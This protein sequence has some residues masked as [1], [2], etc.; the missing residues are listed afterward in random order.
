[1][2]GRKPVKVNEEA[3]KASAVGTEIGDILNDWAVGKRT[4]LDDLR[5]L[6]WA[7]EQDPEWSAF[8]GVMNGA[9]NIK[10]DAKRAET[11]KGVAA[12]ALVH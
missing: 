10:D 5:A 12:L 7:M 3:M 1:M 4:T 2:S 11:L 9:L 8:S 6:R